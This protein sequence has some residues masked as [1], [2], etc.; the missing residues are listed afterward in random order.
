M[1]APTRN[2]A[3]LRA[4][5]ILAVTTAISGCANWQQITGTPKQVCNQWRP[6][7]P[8]RS[9]KLTDGTSRQLAGNNAAQETWCGATPL[10]PSES[11][12]VAEA[13]KP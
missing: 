8:S 5:L 9:D 10:P 6:I 12:K 1:H 11:K 7:W 13:A 4:V 3:R 2:A